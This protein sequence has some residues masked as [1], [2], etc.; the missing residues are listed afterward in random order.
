MRSRPSYD[1]ALRP[2]L[3]S[4]TLP[5]LAALVVAGCGS[6]GG[7]PGFDSGTG[8]GGARGDADRLADVGRLGSSDGNHS[9]GGDGGSNGGGDG[10]DCSPVL[11]GRLR[12]LRQQARLHARI[13]ARRRLRERERATTAASSETGHLG[14]DQK[15][16]YAHGSNEHG[17][18]HAREDASS[19]GG[20]A[21][22]RGQEHRLRFHRAAHD[23]AGGLQTYNNQEFFPLDGRGWDDE[24]VADDGK[25]H[26]FSFTFELH[27]TFGY[28][29][30]ET[31]TFIGDDDVFVFINKKLV[32]DLG[33]VHVA[34]TRSITLDQLVTAD[35]AATPVSLTVG[36]TYPLDIFY[37]ERH[38]VASH[39]RMDH[40][41]R[42]QQL[43]T[44]HRPPL[45]DYSSNENCFVSSVRLSKSSVV[46]DRVPDVPSEP[47]LDRQTGRRRVGEL[48]RHRVLTRD[49][50]LTDEDRRC[51]R[52]VRGNRP[53]DTHSIE[54]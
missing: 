2:A 13:G 44:H 38:T 11:T 14:S 41:D 8:D 18:D 22:H 29:G 53:A 28:K 24:Y 1:R 43:H 39:F 36:T 32:V 49:R 51:P 4:P 47:C 20:T 34:E 26:N 3:V 50:R 15:P 35:T 6:F 21:T 42:V 45:T 31:F 54:H 5:C 48:H 30:D 16:V 17:D 37:N 27:T 19:T 12:G 33:G 9:G 46:A 10:G 7:A 25:M 23:S 40:V 52:S